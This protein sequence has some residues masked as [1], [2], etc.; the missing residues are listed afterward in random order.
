[1]RLHANQNHKENT[2]RVCAICMEGILPSSLCKRQ[3][4]VD[5]GEMS[6]RIV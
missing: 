2:M 4:G 3:A 5:R 1:M 6:R